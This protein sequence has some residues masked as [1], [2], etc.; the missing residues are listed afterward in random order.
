MGWL[1]FFTPRGVKKALVLAILGC[2]CVC[3][4]CEEPSNLEKFGT[5]DQDSS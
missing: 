1:G 5:R 2:K 4:G 3:F